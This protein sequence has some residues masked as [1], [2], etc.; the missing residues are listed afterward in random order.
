MKVKLSIKIISKSMG[1]AVVFGLLIDLFIYLHHVV[2][3]PNDI[4]SRYLYLFIGL[5]LVAIAIC[6]YF[7]SSSIYLPTDFLLKA[8][9]KLAKNYTVGTILWTAIPLSISLIVI[10]YRNDIVGIGPGTLL[11]MFGSGFL[12]DMY[13][14]WIV[15]GKVSNAVEQ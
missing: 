15:I 7:Q 9:G 5:N 11:F 3:V 1:T 10:I 14:R 4:V 12:I 6:I 13:N 8:F 2:F